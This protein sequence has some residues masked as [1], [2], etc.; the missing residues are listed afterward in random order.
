MNEAYLFKQT[1][2]QNDEIKKQVIPDAMD[3]PSQTFDC[4]WKGMGSARIE[5]AMVK[6]GWRTYHRPRFYRSSP[7]YS[8]RTNSAAAATA[9]KK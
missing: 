1:D 3:K 6:A 7:K 2:N 4:N 5:P 8:Q 9:K